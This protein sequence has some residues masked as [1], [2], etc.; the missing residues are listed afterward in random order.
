MAFYAKQIATA[1]GSVDGAGPIRVMAITVIL[2]GVASVPT[3]QCTRDFKQD[4]LFL[5]NVLSF[6]PSTIVLIVMAKSGSGAMAFAWSRVAGQLTSCAVVLAATRLYPPGMSRYGLS[7]LF[8]FGVPWAAA[9]FV[10][11]ILQNVDYV[12]IGHLMGAVR[13]GAYVLAFNAA[14]WPSSLLMGIIFAV[15]MPAFSRLRHDPDRLFDAMTDSVRAVV[16]IAAPL[17]TLLMVLA[18]PLVLT[19]YGARWIAAANA[20]SILA[21]YGLISIVCVL[22]SN[23][24]AALGKSNFILIVQLIWLGLLVPAMVIGVNRSGIDGAAAAHIIVIVPFVLPCYL[25]A[26]RRAT[27]VHITRLAKAAVPPLAAASIAA[28]IAWRVASMLHGSL[29]QLVIG[30]LAGGLSYVLVTA[31]QLVQVVGRDRARDPR[32]RR[33]LRP[34]YLVGQIIGI[35]I[36]PPPRHARRIRA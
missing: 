26:L 29:I 8:K 9:S 17:C 36:G 18:R 14:S 33:L 34:Y 4:K 12:L 1:L 20:L 19:L 22:F 35:P 11:Y 28:F 32:I 6:V 23:M 3:A 24:I 2:V 16:L 15:S 7:V 27:G 13:L 5:A 10:G 31:P 30:V 21:L 25:I